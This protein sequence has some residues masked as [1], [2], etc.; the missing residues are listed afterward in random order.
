MP[1]SNEIDSNADQ[2]LFAANRVE[3]VNRTTGRDIK[4]GMAGVVPG[5]LTHSCVLT[6]FMTSEATSPK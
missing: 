6:S 5:S 3:R 4:A 2:N 1:R